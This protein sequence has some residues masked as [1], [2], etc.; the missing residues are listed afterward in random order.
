MDCYMDCRLRLGIPEVLE[1][2]GAYHGLIPQPK[3]C[4]Q[5]K[6]KREFSTA[7]YLG[8][9]Q[10]NKKRELFSTFILVASYNWK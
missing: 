8:P 7:N 1:V 2:Q 10:L 6:K 5:F 9:K 3:I 4:L